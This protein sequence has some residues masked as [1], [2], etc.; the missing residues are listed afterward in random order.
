M[1]TGLM[2][3]YQ[4]TID[5]VLEHGN[6]LYPSKKVKTKQPDGTLHEYSYRDLFGRVKRLC[7]VL[8]GLGVQ[9]GD[10][11]GTFAWNNYQHV[12]LYF[13][14]PG[15]GAVV[16]TL[17]IRLFPDQLA[18]IINH[19]EDKAI[20]IDATLLP[21]M[22]G[23][24][25]RISGVEHFVLFNGDEGGAEASLPGQ[26]H[27]FETLMAAAEDEYV[28][29]VEGENQAMGLCY[30][31]GTT[32]HPKG[33][34]YSHRSMYLHTVGSCQAAALGLTEDDVVMPVVPQ[35]HAMAWGLPYAAVNVGA[36]LVMPGP[37]MQPAALAEL[38]ETERVT[39]AAGVPTI[40]NGLYHD[41]KQRPR[42]ISC[43]R[44]LVV[45]GSAMPRSLIE[46]YEKELGVNVVHA[47]GMTEMSPLGTVSKL[48]SHHH[49]LPQEERWNVKA[50]Q[51]YPI[52]GVDMRIM[53][54]QGRELP[55]DGETFGEL[56]VRGPWVA[57]A[58]YK[59]EGGDDSFTEDGWFRTGDVVTISADGFMSI[60][61]RT[62]DLVKS[63][64]EWISSVEL[65]N[66]LMAHPQVLEAAVIAVPHERWGERPLAVIVPTDD[67]TPPGAKELRQF[68]EPQVAR[69]WLPD[70]YEFIDEIPKTGTGKFDKKVLRERFGGGVQTVPL[71]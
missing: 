5:R 44:A 30:T 25:D 32:G 34:L 70:G 38:I 54:D 16:H 2:M 11:V 3:D 23:L 14:A 51:G 61:D 59:L 48:L 28:W 26:V 43:I 39:V 36:D 57:Q 6:R 24:G 41:L 21:L 29:Q 67:E 62:K 17:N 68:M 35:F 50:R 42:D 19:A 52:S 15:A 8:K 9:P 58:Y 37:H 49:A 27:D 71:P 46:A 10:R 4:L 55:W 33:A 20:F 69:W 60:T 53:D 66:L 13:G 40:W 45:G 18:Y 56:H 12:E 65:E 63:G 31:S 1:L 22:E 64:G 7:N 47:W